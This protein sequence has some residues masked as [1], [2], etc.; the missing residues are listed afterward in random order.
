MLC[1]PL[2]ARQL[3][4]HALRNS[5][6]IL[7]VN[8]DSPAAVTDCLEAAR[9]ADAPLIIETS[10]WQI[11]GHSYG[12]GDP[13]L[14]VARYLA[15]LAVLANSQRYRHIPVLYHT[16]HI[17]GP[18]TF[19][20]LQAAIQ[21]IPFSFHDQQLLLRASTI[22]LDASDFSEEEN[23]RHVCRLAELALEAGVP[24]T[25]E[26]ES[27][28]DEGLTPEE[29]TRRLIGAVEERYPDHIHL[30]AP[31]LG[32]KHGFHAD[33]YPEFSTRAIE[34]NVRLLRQITGRD[35]GLA[36][37]GSTG[38]SPQNLTDASKAGVT[39]VNWSS[40]SLLIRS[41]AARR[42]YQEME[43]QFDKKHPA[44]KNTVM[45]NGVSNYVAAAYVPTVVEKMRV[46]GGAGMASKAY[47]VLQG[48]PEQTN[49]PA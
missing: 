49:Q 45:D 22:S 27:A 8:A 18:E 37:H 28:V 4:A 19:T 14:G 10:L 34:A 39:K 32:T 11:K 43:E 40:E 47:Q 1:N 20:I 6:A 30:W 15:D 23:I 46:L 38:L 9:Q 7:A 24:V 41:G 17:K 12:A 25:L 3:L 33:G 29:E 21:G 16:D 36:L 2:Q 44:W 35:F 13:V 31:G 26:M 48:Q 42:Y 5:Y